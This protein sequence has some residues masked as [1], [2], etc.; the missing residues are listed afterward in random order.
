MEK[1]EESGKILEESRE[2]GTGKKEE[3]IGII[4]TTRGI[5]EGE[6]GTREWKEGKGKRKTILLEEL[7]S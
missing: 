6:G 7:I 1:K 5:W 3:E 2:E 4:R